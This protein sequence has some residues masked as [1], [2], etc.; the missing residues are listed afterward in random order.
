[1]YVL[2]TFH[3]RTTQAGRASTLPTSIATDRPPQSVVSFKKK[4]HRIVPEDG[5]GVV[6]PFLQ[7]AVDEHHLPPVFVF[8]S[9]VSGGFIRSLLSQSNEHVGGK[10]EATASRLFWA[11]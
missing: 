2:Y 1:M 7:R 4:T 10:G 5:A 8:V 11:D 3:V 9:C 6:P